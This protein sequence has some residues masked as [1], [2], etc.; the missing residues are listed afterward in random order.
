M[1]VNTHKQK[2]TVRES[3]GEGQAG[4][5]WKDKR[6]ELTG[7]HKETYEG[8][9]LLSTPQIQGAQAKDALTASWASLSRNWERR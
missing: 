8:S 2:D 4:K 6:E 5:L 7:G 1:Y 9:S 3:M